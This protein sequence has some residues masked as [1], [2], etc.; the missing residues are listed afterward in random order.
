[1]LGDY[2]GYTGVLCHSATTNRAPSVPPGIKATTTYTS[3]G[4]GTMCEYAPLGGDS[5]K[6]VPFTGTC[7]FQTRGFYFYYYQ[8]V[9]VLPGTPW[10]PINSTAPWLNDAYCTGTPG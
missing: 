1:V 2:A 4:Y 5:T 6:A 9:M 3:N 10:G 8:G 7:A